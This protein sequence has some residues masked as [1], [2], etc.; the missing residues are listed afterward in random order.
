VSTYGCD[1]ANHIADLIETVK[2][3]WRKG[4]GWC[5]PW[6]MDY[7]DEDGGLVIDGGDG[8]VG[9]KA[10]GTHVD[11][12]DGGC[13]GCI[14]DFTIDPTPAEGTVTLISPWHPGGDPCGGGLEF[15]GVSE[16]TYVVTLTV[17]DPCPADPD[18][19][20]DVIV[21]VV[22][23]TSGC[24]CG[25]D[26]PTFG[27]V[28]CNLAVNPVDVVYMVNYVYKGLDARCYPAGWNCPY[29]LGD[30]N[31]DFA[32]NPV[33]VVYYVNYVYKGN[34]PFPCNGCTIVP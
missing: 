17:A 21:A 3:A 34:T 32:V 31:C 14:F 33:D 18:H 6:W 22:E 12:I 20:E 23:V 11:G 13:C 28:D 15:V 1:H 30:V 8:V 16:G 29:D 9:F 26:Y 24:F 19:Q 5:E 27:D 2:E 25:G 7:E 4:F 10:T